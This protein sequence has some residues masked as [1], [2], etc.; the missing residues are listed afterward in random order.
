MDHLFIIFH[1][2]Y[3]KIKIATL[4]WFLIFIISLFYF[5]IILFTID[6]V[7]NIVIL[8]TFCII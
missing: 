2:F 7:L 1:K 6:L 8:G 3:Q 4:F 5:I